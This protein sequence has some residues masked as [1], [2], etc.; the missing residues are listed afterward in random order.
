MAV[1][2]TRPY[3]LGLYDGTKPSTEVMISVDHP[4][5][6]RPKRYP[7]SSFSIGEGGEIIITNHIE[8]GRIT[9]LSSHYV[10]VTFDA[11]FDS[12]PV[13]RGNLYVYKTFDPGDGKVVD[14]DIPIYGIE[15][16]TSGFSFYI[17]E[18]ESLTGV[19]CEYQF[20]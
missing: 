4:D 3:E 13:G 10:E 2:Q 1:T 6:V 9:G 19:I 8:S 11:T 18:T 20:M 5:W 15:V 16:S 12:V 7:L 17:E 14:L